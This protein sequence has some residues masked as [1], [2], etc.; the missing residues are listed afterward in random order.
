MYIKLLIE[1]RNYLLIKLLD[2]Q[3]MYKIDYVW[4]GFGGIYH[5]K[6]TY[7]FRSADFEFKMELASFIYNLNKIV[8]MYL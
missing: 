4:N 5:P 2:A 8:Q 3:A 6:Y 1:K 7:N